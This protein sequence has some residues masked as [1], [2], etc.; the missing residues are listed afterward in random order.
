MRASILIL[1][2]A[3]GGSPPPAAPPTAAAPAPAVAPAAVVQQRLG[4]LVGRWQAADRIE[5]WVAAGDALFGASFT[6][7]QGRTVEWEALI[8]KDAGGAVVYEAAPNGAAPTA[9]TL[10][11]AGEQAA[12]F[13]N[14]GHDWPRHIGYRREGDRLSAEV[15]GKGDRVLKLQWTLAGPGAAPE[16][17][18]ADR[19]WSDEVE[20]RGVDAWVENFDPE[21]VQRGSREPRLAG[22]DAIRKAMEP[23]LAGSFRLIWQP[24]ASGWSPAGDTGYTVGTYRYL[25]GNDEQ[26]RGAYITLWRRQPDGSWRVLYDAGD[27]EG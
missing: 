2:V 10:G 9:F 12:T 27:P 16:L 11:E 14:A 3:C 5:H 6:V 4:W 20:R 21:G 15:Q 26:G 8:V 23:V 1:L 22:A 19:R 24:V 7:E 13:V 17:E 18:A 25:A